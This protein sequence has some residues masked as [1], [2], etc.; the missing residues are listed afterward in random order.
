MVGDPWLGLTPGGR[1]PL[2]RET[3]IDR[4]STGRAERARR[5]SPWSHRRD[6]CW[7][8]LVLSFSLSPSPSL[9]DF[10]SKSLGD[11][12][13]RGHRVDR[14]LDPQA[15]CATSPSSSVATHW[16]LAC[17]TTSARRCTPR[18][19]AA[20]A[21][22]AIGRTGT[23]SATLAAPSRRCIAMARLCSAL[24]TLGGIVSEYTPTACITWDSYPCNASSMHAQPRHSSLVRGEVGRRMSLVGARLSSLVIVVE[25]QG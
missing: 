18:R 21:S 13:N 23:T 25:R 1:H 10:N 20:S 4:S 19:V 6:V 5:L 8:R 14:D 12:R 11:M 17:P 24:Q 15:S 16:R 3:S 22:G 2:G 7:R 9:S